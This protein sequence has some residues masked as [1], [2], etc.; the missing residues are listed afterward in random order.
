MTLDVKIHLDGYRSRWNSIRVMYLTMFIS[1]VTFTITMST[2]WPYLRVVSTLTLSKLLVKHFLPL[3]VLSFSLNIFCHRMHLILTCA[4]MDASATPSLLGWVVA[5]FS[6]GQLVASPIFGL[7]STKRRSSREPLGV[8]LLLQV[9]ANVFYAYVPS[10]D[11]D[12]GLYLAAARCLMGFA[13][14][15]GGVVSL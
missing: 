5:A 4:Q 13:S 7:W 15:E 2:I 9:G 6:L 11:G 10:V 1:A 3:I 14:G 12:R 8:S